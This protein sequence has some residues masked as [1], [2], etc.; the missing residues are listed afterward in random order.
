M[1][2]LASP[3]SAFPLHVKSPIDLNRADDA[4]DHRNR[5]QI[6]KINLEVPFYTGNQAIL[7]QGA[8]HRFP[9][10]GNP[11]MGGNFILS[12]H[13]FYLGTSPGQ[14]KTRSPFYRLDKLKKGDTLRV[15]YNNKWY[16]YV[17]DHTYSVKPGET[18]IEAPSQTAKLTLYSCS[19]KGEADGRVVV[20]AVPSQ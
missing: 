9:E 19:L 20:E 11:E 1:L 6:A 16:S 10:I 14:T 18:S 8:W 7:S 12:A 15:F 3:R 4:N 13:R 17:V 5:I 2:L